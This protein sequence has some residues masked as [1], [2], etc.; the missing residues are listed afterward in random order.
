MLHTYNDIFIA[1]LTLTMMIHTH[2][3]KQIYSLV[4]EVRGRSIEKLRIRSVSVG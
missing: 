2:K 1:K 4:T 3:H